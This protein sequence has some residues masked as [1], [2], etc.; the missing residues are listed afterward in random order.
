[1]LFPLH[2]NRRRGGETTIAMDDLMRERGH[3]RESGRV[4][5]EILGQAA[6]AAEAL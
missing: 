5:D 1:M 4:A 3:I 2:N 6:E